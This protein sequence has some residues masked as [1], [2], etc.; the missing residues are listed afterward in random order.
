MTAAARFVFEPAA[1]LLAT[2]GGHPMHALRFVIAA[3]VLIPC[4]GLAI[5]PQGSFLGTPQNGLNLSVCGDGIR[6]PGELCFE[7]PVLV[8]ST[9]SDPGWVEVGYINGGANLDVVASVPASDQIRIKLGSGDGT[10][11][12]FYN[13]SMGTNPIGV[14]LADFNGDGLTDII[15]ARYPDDQIR[16]RWGHTN[17]S[18]Y[19]NYSTDNGPITVD[20]GDLNGDGLD[21]FVTAGLSLTLTVRLRLPAGGFTSQSYAG[22]SGGYFVLLGDTNNDGHLDLIYPGAS[23]GSSRMKVRLNDGSGSFGAAQN[24]NTG[25]TPTP[26]DLFTVSDYNNDGDLDIV[27]I[28][29]DTL[30]RVLGNGNGTFGGA[31][32]APLAQSPCRIRS[33]D[34]DGDG[35]EDFIIGNQGDSLDIYLGDGNGNFAPARHF[36]N[37]PGVCDINAGDFNGDGDLDIVFGGAGGVYLMIANP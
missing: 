25:N 29:D 33:F 8:T 15:A 12:A 32:T 11:G 16:I 34:V 19:S 5:S 14:K 22:L 36:D 13:W 26:I 35:D 20:V 7:S 1:G 37:L 21:D 23:G 3:I 18:T 2:Q 31:A 9:S 28:R 27:A 10:F 24:V 4:S 6:S 30:V 17:W